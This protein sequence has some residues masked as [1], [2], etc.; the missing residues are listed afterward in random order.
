MAG[1]SGRAFRLQARRHGAGLTSTEMVSSYGV[2]YRNTRTLGMLALG[3]AERPVAVQL[4]GS[5]PGV[6]A[7]A[8]AVAESAGADII[9]INMGCPVR[10]VIKTGAGVALMEDERLAARIVAGV[11]A[12]VSAPVTAKIRSGARSRITALSLAPRLEE[13]GAAAI[14][15][16]P[17]LGDAGSKDRADHSVT[18]EIVDMVGIPVIASGDVRAPANAADLLKAGCAAVMAARAALG[19]PWLFADLLAERQPHPRPPAEVLGE[20]RLFYAGLVDEAGPELAGRAMRKFY[21]WYLR[22]F[23]PPAALRDGLRRAADFEEAAGLI[24]S[25]LL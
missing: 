21:G 16:H 2:H 15:I 7:A 3:A 5:D 11:A 1:V 9:D 8:A 13:A 19:N 25:L 14:C 24:R 22:P 4:F 6:M 17:R 12:A 20:M 23:R 10:K 18:K